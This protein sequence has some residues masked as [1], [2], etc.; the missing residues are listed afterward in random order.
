MEEE[1]Q[2]Y[3]RKRKKKRG[4]KKNENE[5]MIEESIA[6]SFDKGDSKEILELVWFKRNQ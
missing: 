2:D 4:E 5:K 3:E 6:Q 1:K